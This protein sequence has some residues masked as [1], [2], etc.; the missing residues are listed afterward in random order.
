MN[1]IKNFLVFGVV[2][3]S[4]SANA[5]TAP[6]VLVRE[7]STE[8][9]EEIKNDSLS[10]KADINKIMQLVDTKIMPHVNFKK[11]TASTIGRHWRQA[12]SE[13]QTELEKEFKIL[14]IRTYSGALSQ[15]TDQ[16]IFFKPL[17]ASTDDVEVIV[18]SEV[19]GRGEPIQLNYRVEKNEDGAWK[20]IDLSVMG[21]WLV[22]AYK[23]Q[24]NQEINRN[25]IDGLINTIKEKNKSNQK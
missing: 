17:R 6:D 11:M 1:I 23:N 3:L 21:A 4:F 8:V 22:D 18:K 2:A 10:K 19:R 15:I 5:T 24:F 25:G 7:V 20:V 14:L 12:T 13:Q 16:K 9:I